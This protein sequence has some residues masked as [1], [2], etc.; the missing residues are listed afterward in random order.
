MPGY[1]ESE[2]KAVWASL[3]ASASSPECYTIDYHRADEGSGWGT[4]FFFG[5]PGAAG[6]K[7]C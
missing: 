1:F 7:S 5:G 3:H 2:D 4:Y 6:G